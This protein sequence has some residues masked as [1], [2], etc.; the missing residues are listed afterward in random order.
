MLAEATAHD[1]AFPAKAAKDLDLWTSALQPLFDTDTVTEAEMEI[2]RAHAQATRQVVSDRILA[3]SIEVAQDQFPG[4][5]PIRAALLQ[6]FARAEEQCTQTLRKVANQVPEIMEGQV[7]VFCTQQQ[8][9]T[10]MV[11]AQAG[12]PIHLGVNNWAAMAS[13]T[14]LFAQVILGLGSL[15]GCAAMPEQVKYTPYLRRGIRWS[16]PRYFPESKS[17]RKAQLPVPFT[18]AMILTPEYHR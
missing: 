14:R 4:R 13:M 10:S 6:S 18:W 2:R 16:R 17:R 8:G 3:W 11:V 12:V 7:G 5:G 1:Q 9:I 15:H